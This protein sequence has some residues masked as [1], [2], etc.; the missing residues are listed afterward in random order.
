GALFA[1]ISLASLPYAT[2]MGARLKPLRDFF[3][4]LFFVSLGET[5][6]FTQ[7]SASL[8]PA[9]ILSAIVILGKPLFVMTTLGTMGYTRL[10]SFK[11]AIH[12]SQISEFSIILVVF[13]NSVGL[14]SSSALAIITLVAIITIGVSTYLMKYD[15]ALYKQF[16]NALG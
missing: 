6:A 11:A 2:Q 16:K 15:D 7:L 1:G 10:T 4:V 5:F 3:I 14:V 13:A 8:I 12:L 9:L